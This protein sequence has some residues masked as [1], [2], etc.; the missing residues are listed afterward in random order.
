MRA[1]ASVAS[2]ASPPSAMASTSSSA[3]ASSAAAASICCAASAA[4][5]ACR[6]C[7]SCTRCLA[8]AIRRAASA[9]RSAALRYV[10]NE[11]CCSVAA[12][13]AA[14]AAA[15]AA[16]AAVT[17]GPAAP[18]LLAPGEPESGGAAPLLPLDP[19]VLTSLPERCRLANS[20][21]AAVTAASRASLRS[22]SGSDRSGRAACREWQAGQRWAGWNPGAANCSSVRGLPAPAQ[23]PFCNFLQFP[24]NS[25]APSP[26]SADGSAACP[27]SV[28][29][30]APQ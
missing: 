11:G 18:A 25:A 13:V 15:P 21:R 1:A 9:C 30:A 26:G 4:A 16:A 23:Q 8:A 27:S 14:A 28:L 2:R 24:S 5:A 29:A 20:S 7:S 6:S 3:V 17:A 12:A 10:S 19:A 22:V